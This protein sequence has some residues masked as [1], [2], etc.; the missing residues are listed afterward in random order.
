MSRIRSRR[1]KMPADLDLSYAEELA[2]RRGGG[3]VEARAL[4]ARLDAHPLKLPT[5]WQ[6]NALDAAAAGDLDGAYRWLRQAREHVAGLGA[7]R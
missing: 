1:T 5:F 6:R 4:V 3:S 7:Q 2:V